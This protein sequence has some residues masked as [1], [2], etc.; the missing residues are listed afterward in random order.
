MDFLL[1]YIKTDSGILA[2]PAF[3]VAD[4]AVCVGAFLLVIVSFS[5]KKT[6]K[7]KSEK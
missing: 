2:Y 4:I 7:G 6:V 3:N 1:F 5:A